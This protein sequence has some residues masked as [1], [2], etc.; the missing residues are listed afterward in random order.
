MSQL[1]SVYREAQQVRARV[2]RIQ[3]AIANAGFACDDSTAV[4]ILEQG[5]AR[6]T[7]NAASPATRTASSTAACVIS[8]R[9]ER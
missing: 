6:E 7:L 1:Q 5:Y 4:R 9:N 2:V 8:A 3:E